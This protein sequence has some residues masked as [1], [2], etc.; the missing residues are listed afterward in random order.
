MSF[1]PF[2]SP[3]LLHPRTQHDSQPTEPPQKR[4]KIN[5]DVDRQP[6]ADIKNTSPPGR[7]TEVSGSNGS[8]GYYLVL[9]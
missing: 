7:P 3:L 6:L 1:K 5:I 2:K 4:Q 9:W 8:E